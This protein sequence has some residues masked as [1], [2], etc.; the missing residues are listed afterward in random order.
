[1]FNN[2]S[3]IF[4]IYSSLLFEYTF[5]SH[6]YHPLHRQVVPAVTEPSLL[7]TL[8]MVLKSMKRY[9]E[10]TKF[11]ERAYAADGKEKTALEY[12]FCLV[13]EGNWAI[14][15]QVA[16]KMFAKFKKDEYMWWGVVSMWMNGEKA[17]GSASANRSGSSSS[18]PPPLKYAFPLFAPTPSSLSISPSETETYTQ[19]IQSHT[20]KSPA[21]SLV[22]RMI[23]KSFKD[24]KYTNLTPQ[25]VIFYLLLLQKQGKWATCLE[26]LEDPNFQKGL[27]NPEGAL[28][29]RAQYHTFLAYLSE[30]QRQKE[31]REEG[32]KVEVEGGKTH[33]EVRDSHLTCAFDILRKLL[34]EYNSDE[35]SYYL[36]YLDILA[37]LGGGSS[38]LV[39][40]EGVKKFAE[41]E[42]FLSELSEREPK[43]LKNEESSSSS[44]KKKRLQ[45]GP[46][47]ARI[48]GHFRLLGGSNDSSPSEDGLKGF[49]DLIL[50]Y[51]QVF[52]SS[53]FIFLY[54]PLF[55]FIF[56]YFPFPFFLPSFLFSFFPP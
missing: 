52:L 39:S 49:V 3:L 18:S 54:F 12:F 38:A 37:I 4:S 9:G 20:S 13:R 47:L 22:E 51:F 10:H 41:F 23:S 56:L 53:Y 36:S 30:N 43:S 19:H 8:S 26:T 1:M 11:C 48:E 50:D 28:F 33:G 5:Y 25:K 21:A 14:A 32:E 29:L 45:R 34:D 7:E 15:Q 42:E 35:W 2:F 44:S 16:T 31:E 24:H 40:P 17:N 55:F 46:F 27:Q 6:D